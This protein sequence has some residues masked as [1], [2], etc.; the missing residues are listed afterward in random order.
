M[1]SP[2]LPWRRFHGGAEDSRRPTNV[3][4]AGIQAFITGIHANKQ[5]PYPAERGV[6]KTA[7]AGKSRNLFVVVL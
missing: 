5:Y 6:K 1:H 4:S 3:I 7:R 2:G